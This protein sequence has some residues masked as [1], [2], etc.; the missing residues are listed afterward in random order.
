M[1]AERLI[2]IAAISFAVADFVVLE[3]VRARNKAKHVTVQRLRQL[4][5]RFAKEGSS[6]SSASEHHVKTK[7][8]HSEQYVKLHTLLSVRE[9]NR[10]YCSQWIAAPGRLPCAI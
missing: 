8:E 6:G 2:L 9:K 3:V 5:T 4:V 1:G 7:R 10:Y